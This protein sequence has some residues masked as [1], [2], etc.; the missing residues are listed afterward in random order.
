[1]DVLKALGA[2]SS[3]MLTSTPNALVNY[4]L[5]RQS[6]KYAH[7]LSMQ[8]YGKRYQMAAEDM[9]RAG[10]NPLMALR[11]GLGSGSAPQAMPT[12]PSSGISSGVDVRRSEVEEMNVRSQVK[13]RLNQA[14][15]RNSRIK[16]DNSTS[17]LNHLLGRKYDSE[18]A[19]NEV[20]RGTEIIEQEV[21]NMSIKLMRKDVIIKDKTI[22]FKEFRNQIASKIRLISREILKGLKGK[23]NLFYDYINWLLKGY[24]KSI[25]DIDTIFETFKPREG[26]R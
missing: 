9:R 22:F 24:F 25:W 1:M 18:R 20:K 26:M 17:K 14:L 13:D 6:T 5:G 8:A 21:K 16:L 15:A 23:E 2:G 3:A 7:D 12:L 19:Y 11:G 4:Y 10:L